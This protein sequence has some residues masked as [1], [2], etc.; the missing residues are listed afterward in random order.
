M[1]LT[2]NS[3]HN[4]L[5]H[6]IELDRRDNAPHKLEENNYSIVDLDI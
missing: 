6:E 2:L 4:Y 5:G 1:E 3:I